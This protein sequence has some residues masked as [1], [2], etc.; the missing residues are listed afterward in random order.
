MRRDMTQNDT[1]QL[2]VWFRTDEQGMRS[3]ELGSGFTASLLDP[4]IENGC[5]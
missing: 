4:C 3:T 5:Q 2:L 1:I